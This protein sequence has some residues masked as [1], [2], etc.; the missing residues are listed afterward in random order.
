VTSVSSLLGDRGDPDVD[1]TAHDTYLTGVPY[2]AFERLRSLGPVVE[3]SEAEGGTHWAV[4]DHGLVGEVGRD[5]RRFTSSSGIRL[6][7]MDEAALHHRRTLM[8]TDP[9]GHTRLR[10]IL[11]KG[12]TPRVVAGFEDGFRI[13]VGTMLDH[14][15]DAEFVDFAEAV[16]RALPVRLL[17]RLLGV[18]DSDAERLVGWTDRLVSNTDPEFSDV[19]V[20]RDTSGEYR[21]LPFRSPAALE[22]FRY[23][24]ECA[25]ER[26][27]RPTEDVISS[28]LDARIEGEPLTDLEF[29]NFFTLL[30]V[31]GNETT[32]HAINHAV[33]LMIDRPELLGR[34]RSDRDVMVSGG[35]EEFLRA[36]SVTM[37]FRRTA[38]EDTTLGPATIR[39]G[40]KVVMWY[41]ASNVDPVVFEQP[42]G[43]DLTRR[44]NP[45]HAFG[46]GPHSCLGASFARLE[47]RVVIEEL[48]A[49]VSGITATGPIERLRSN[50]HNG[51]K[52]LP[53]RLAPLEGAGAG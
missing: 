23:A 18:P 30:M 4:L 26:R 44:P 5:W 20:D 51:I 40:D 37:H 13:L 45:H 1:V 2:A 49:R 7:E 35:T 14:A 8:E 48:T 32:R 47:L 3:L 11:Q 27:A 52:R 24:E 12:F 21:L 43:I 50:F 19:V 16:S 25:M 36:A 41:L 28:L 29:K 22:V 17:C 42:H 53:V 34:I 38:T 10:R 46:V 15:L 6:E 33:T 31:A 39:K 9:P